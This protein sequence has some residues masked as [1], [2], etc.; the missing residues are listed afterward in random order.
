M[1]AAKLLKQKS[2]PVERGKSKLRQSSIPCL[3]ANFLLNG[4]V[5]GE[6]NVPS[7]KIKRS[8][9]DGELFEIS[10]S[11]LS[12]P[13]CVAGWER[14]RFAMN[15]KCLASGPLSASQLRAKKMKR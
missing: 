13:T 12:P 9:L 6:T 14:A 11:L 10:S 1:S 7:G 15:A 8:N 5:R 4:R 2:K 3:S